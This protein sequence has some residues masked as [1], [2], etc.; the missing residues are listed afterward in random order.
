MVTSYYRCTLY[1]IIFLSISPRIAALETFNGDG[2]PL[3]LF[4]LASRPSLKSNFFLFDLPFFPR[5]D[6]FS[7]THVCRPVSSTRVCR[8]G[9]PGPSAGAGLDRELF[10]FFRR[11]LTSACRKKAFVWFRSLDPW[12]RETYSYM[13]NKPTRPRHLTCNILFKLILYIC[14]QV[15][16][17]NI[18]YSFRTKIK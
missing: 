3:Q 5:V 2:D 4:Y 8:L 10:S 17:R 7:S 15:C 16:S 18:S 14:E 6:P 11:H 13:T 9:W 1:H 12:H